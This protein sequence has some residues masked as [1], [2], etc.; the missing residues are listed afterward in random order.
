M[1]FKKMRD[2][3]SSELGSLIKERLNNMAYHASLHLYVQ[4]IKNGCNAVL[5]YV[6]E[7]EKSL[8]NEEE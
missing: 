5:E 4:S 2:L 7:Y 6:E 3:T 1:E 8:K